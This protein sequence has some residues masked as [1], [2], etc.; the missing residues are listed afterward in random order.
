MSTYAIGDLQGCYDELQQLLQVINYNADK[1][2]LWFAGDLVNRGPKSL[3]T[4]RFIKS[5]TNAVTVLGNHDLHLLAIANGHPYTKHTLYEILKAPDCDELINW[6]RQQPLLHYDARLGFVM[7]HA[8]IPPQWTL[9]QAK[10]YAAEVEAV[11]RSDSYP[12]FLKHLYSDTPVV[13]R[14]DLSGWDRLRFITDA[15]TRLRFCNAQG[16]LDLNAKGGLDSQP[17][18]YMPWFAVPN[19]ATANLKIVFGHWA[20][21][22]G[23]TN[24]P[25]VYALDTGCVWG[26]YLS[27]LRLE[28]G[29]WFRVRALKASI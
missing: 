26:R 19:R 6:L 14:P 29:K 25:N 16:N 7:T 24:T 3:E 1:D 10:N 11:L 18:G 27:A 17:E 23:I 15:L 2:Q 20:A 5:L 28:D 21:L 13:W 12:E 22:E 4:L 9:E 8:G